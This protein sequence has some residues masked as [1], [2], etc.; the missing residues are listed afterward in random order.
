MLRWLLRDIFTSIAI[1]A[2]DSC[3]ALFFGLILLLLYYSTMYNSE[4][5]LNSP[6]IL[7]C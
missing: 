1:F 3:T 2:L 5:L 6:L 4:G 7:Q